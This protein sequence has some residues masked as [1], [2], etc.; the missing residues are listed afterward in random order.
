MYVFTH[1]EYSNLKKRT[2]LSPGSILGATVAMLM[3]DLGSRCD[4]SSCLQSKMT[5]RRP[6]LFPTRRPFSRGIVL[7]PFLPISSWLACLSSGNLTTL[8]GLLNLA[9]RQGS[10]RR[11]LDHSR[12]LI[13]M[14]EYANETSTLNSTLLLPGPGMVSRTI[15]GNR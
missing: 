4:E 5:G 2:V 11:A 12:S 8:C 13:T 15:E 10:P 9:E 14:D 6:T 1:T 3:G 7:S